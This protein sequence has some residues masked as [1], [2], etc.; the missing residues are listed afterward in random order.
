M[1]DAIIWC[2]VFGGGSIISLITAQWYYD[3][4]DERALRQQMR[5]KQQLRIHPPVHLWRI[6]P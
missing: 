4:C 1:Q 2:V 6:T 3:K 5:Q